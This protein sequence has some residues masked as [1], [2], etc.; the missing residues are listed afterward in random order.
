M[1]PEHTFPAYDLALDLGAD[2]LELDVHMTRDGVLVALHDA[3]LDRVTGTSG[4][5]ADSSIAELKRLDAG[6]WFGPGWR[7]LSIPTLAEVFARYGRRTR[8]YVE[9]KDP[10]LYPGIEDELLRL[11][12]SHGLGGRVTV[13]SFSG[14][15]VERTA[16]AGIPVVRL[17][18]E[19]AP[20]DPVLRAAA[21]Y[22]YAIGACASD[23]GRGLVRQA[24]AL[25][26]GVFAYGADAPGATAALAE[27]G[28]DGV[29][30]DW[31]GRRL[32]AAAAPV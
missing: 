29:F 24:H 20:I 15:C 32:P 9:L 12:E 25:G 1:A 14:P 10:E 3:T 19:G 4:F 22:A 5:V 17:C 18:R 16:A 27:A 13:M 7:G 21:G 26:L 8:Y 30:T 23:L 31:P 2:G 6:S 11:V 28:V